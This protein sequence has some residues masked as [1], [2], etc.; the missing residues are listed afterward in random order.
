LLQRPLMKKAI[1]QQKPRTCCKAFTPA[2][3]QW[4]R[5][6]HRIPAPQLMHPDELTVEQMMQKFGVSRHVVY[7]W[8]ERGIVEARQLKRGTPY[9]ISL[10]TKKKQAL[11]TWVKHSSR[12]SSERHSETPL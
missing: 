9:W 12:I 4:V 8:I 3:I 7:Y 6:R 1:S 5:Y 10:D 2:M 11:Y